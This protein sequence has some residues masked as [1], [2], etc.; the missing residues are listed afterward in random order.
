VV[1]PVQGNIHGPIQRSHL[2]QF[3]NAQE[4]DYIEILQESFSQLIIEKFPSMLFK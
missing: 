3:I 1:K 2:E 4:K